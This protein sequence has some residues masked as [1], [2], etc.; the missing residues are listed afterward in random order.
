MAGTPGR[1][2]F[3][4]RVRERLTLGGGSFG[5]ALGQP[6]RALGQ[7][8]LGLRDPS[9]LEGGVARGC[10]SWLDGHVSVRIK[11]GP[12]ESLRSALQ[13][14]WAPARRGMRT[15]SGMGRGD[16]ERRRR[17]TGT[18]STPGVWVSGELPPG[19][20]SVNQAG[21]PGQGEGGIEP[22][23]AETPAGRAAP[24]GRPDQG[25]GEQL[26]SLVRSPG[27]MVLLPGPD[28][29]QATVLI[30]RQCPHSAGANCPPRA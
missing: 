24:A 29:S 4:K 11:P 3:R 23:V 2:A 8:G 6:G 22:P 5:G 18:R 9:A 19:W 20:S 25:R 7:C 27:V 14:S 13:A 12:Q 15:W 21:V 17:R 10:P 30:G 16:E 28:P 1:R 26:T